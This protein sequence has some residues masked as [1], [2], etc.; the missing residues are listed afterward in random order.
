M[1]FRHR[2]LSRR[3]LLGG[4]IGAAA[5]VALAAC[6]DD[7]HAGQ[8]GDGPFPPPYPRT[9]EHRFGSTRIESR[10]QRIVCLG[11][12]DADALLAAGVT[13]VAT[14]DRLDVGPHGI[15]PWARS[16]PVG[17]PPEV[18]PGPEIDLDRV[19]ALAP[20]LVTFTRSDVRA[21]WERLSKLAPTIAGRPGVLPSAPRGTEPPDTS[22]QDQAAMIAWAA[23]DVPPTGPRSVTEAMAAVAAVKKRNPG[24]A[25]RTVAVATVVDGR[26]HA[27]LRPDERLRFME[28]L[29]FRNSPAVEGTEPDM[30]NPPRYVTTFS[31]QQAARLDADLTVVL[32]GGDLRDDPMLTGIPSARAGRLLVVDDVDLANAL[33]TSSVL[34]IPY[35]LERFVPL[36]RRAL[37]L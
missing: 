23:S 14:L 24:F 12:G 30:S 26:Y 13:P 11:R 1:R 4:G 21:V 18:L 9:V 34:S 10:P 36:M 27:Y 22:W 28:A 35:A 5:G 37:S 6:G 15:G 3:I 32:G 33:A 8:G 25:G 17:A 19:A 20:D 7:D 16:T 2:A 29:G 31:R